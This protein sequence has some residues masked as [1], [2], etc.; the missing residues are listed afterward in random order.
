MMFYPSVALP[1]VSRGLDPNIDPQLLIL[2]GPGAAV[3]HTQAHPVAWNFPGYPNPQPTLAPPPGRFSQVP[4]FAGH[5]SG[6]IGYQQMAGGVPIIPGVFHNVFPPQAPPSTPPPLKRALQPDSLATPTRSP[7]S[8]KKKKSRKKA[9][10][11]SPTKA[12]APVPAHVLAAQEKVSGQLHWPDEESDCLLHSLIDP[13][14]T[15]VDK[16]DLFDANPSHAYKKVATFSC[17]NLVC[18]L[19]SY[20]LAGCR[21]ETIQHPHTADA[22]KSHFECMWSWF[23]AIL[24]FES[25]TG[26]AG[27]AD[28]EDE[29]IDDRLMNYYARHLDASCITA[30]LYNKW[31]NRGWYTLFFNQ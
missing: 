26:G 8:P 16:P 27:D 24:D 2:G 12:P 18:S 25:F 13:N 17:L 29:S 28:D 22:V 6:P 10:T 11:A 4:P 5:L 20:T 31:K 14:S 7:V 15:F 1:V 3:S 19:I 9:D 21:C 23:K 30:E